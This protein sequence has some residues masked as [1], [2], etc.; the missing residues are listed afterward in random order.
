MGHPRPHKNIRGRSLRRYPL[1]EVQIDVRRT[2]MALLP[3]LCQSRNREQKHMPHVRSGSGDIFPPYGGN[4]IITRF[5]SLCDGH[6]GMGLSRDGQE[7]ACSH[8]CRL[9]HNLE[10]FFRYAYSPDILY[11]ISSMTTFPSESLPR[12]Y[13]DSHCA[14]YD[15]FESSFLFEPEDFSC[16]HHYAS[17]EASHRSLPFARAHRT[18]LHR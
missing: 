8:H 6:G 9:R 13:L 10:S 18:G 2:L 4:I 5:R 16:C 1:L 7:T 12:R 17:Y 15:A 3:G 14:S 11:L